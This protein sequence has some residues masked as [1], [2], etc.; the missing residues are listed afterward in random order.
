MKKILLG[1][2]VLFVLGIM[3]IVAVVWQARECAGRELSAGTILADGTVAGEK[4]ALVYFK[5]HEPEI[6][7]ALMAIKPEKMR[8]DFGLNFVWFQRVGHCRQGQK[9][10]MIRQIGNALHITPRENLQGCG[11]GGCYGF[12]A[13]TSTAAV[14]EECSEYEFAPGAVLPDGTVAGEKEAL[15][16]FNA[17]NPDIFK[18]LKALSTQEMRSD[19]GKYFV[20]FQRVGNCRKR[21]KK[22]SIAQLQDEL[23][24]RAL[25]TEY[26]RTTDARKRGA[27]RGEIQSGLSSVFNSDIVL[28]NMELD[29]AKHALEE[30]DESFW[31]FLAGK[32][33]ARQI[34]SAIKTSEHEISERVRNY[35]MVIQDRLKT[36]LEK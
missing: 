12:S 17:N 30:D 36:L 19:L 13:G 20:W 7:K 24:I 34:K 11:N 22:V 2:A 35:D 23:R 3:G 26:R 16:Y 32:I 33:E 27:I 1:I 28:M 25:V 6:Y 21:Q 9:G 15:N 5:R 31:H 8:T 4:Q 29:N 10:E 14:R 18:G